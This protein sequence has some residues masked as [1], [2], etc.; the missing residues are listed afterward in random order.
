MKKI[1]VGVDGSESSEKAAKKAA[2]LADNLDAE[3][4]LIHVYTENP[5]GL[6]INSRTSY[7]PK[8]EM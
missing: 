8:E 2:V 3:V 5:E 6:R 1:L 4:T 7:L